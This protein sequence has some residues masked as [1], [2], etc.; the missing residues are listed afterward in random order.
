MRDLERINLFWKGINRHPHKTTKRNAIVLLNPEGLNDVKTSN[1]QTI[2]H[3][4]F[5]TVQI[6]NTI[7]S[8]QITLQCGYF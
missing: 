3:K 2:L 1:N 7:A 5:P 6:D 4:K 8:S